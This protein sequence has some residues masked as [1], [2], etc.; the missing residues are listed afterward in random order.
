MKW[1]NSDNILIFVNFDKIAFVKRSL[2]ILRFLNKQTRNL[3]EP[4]ACTVLATWSFFDQFSV[5]GIILSSKQFV[6][7]FEENLTFIS[8][9]KF[10]RL[11]LEKCISKNRLDNLKDLRVNHEFHRR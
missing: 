11:L 5:D 6:G 8:M 7:K 2:P 1:N 3:L 10:N 9:I 4:S